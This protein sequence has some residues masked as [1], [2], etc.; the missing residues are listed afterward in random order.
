MA[1]VT[2]FAG[3]DTRSLPEIANIGNG[4][5]YYGTSGGNNPGPSP[6]AIEYFGSAS[7][8]Y[9]TLHVILV[10]G[11]SDLQ[12]GG[13]TPFAMTITEIDAYASGVPVHDQ[14]YS[15]SR[16][17]AAIQRSPRGNRRTAS[18]I[19]SRPRYSRATTR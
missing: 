15:I 1:I 19:P 14:L 3:I 2:A 10:G 16:H 7:P 4:S 17:L 8:F 13:G 6:D 9:T 11:L 18:L 5:Q 12:L